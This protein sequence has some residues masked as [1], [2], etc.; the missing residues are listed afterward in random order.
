[1]YGG[2]YGSVKGKIY[3]YVISQSARFDGGT[4]IW[5]YFIHT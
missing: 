5:Q 2:F 3:I 4:E 1:V